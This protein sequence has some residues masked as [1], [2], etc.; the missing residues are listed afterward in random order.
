MEEKNWLSEDY[1][2][3][4]ASKELNK[5][6]R[7]LMSEEEFQEY[8]ENGNISYFN[9]VGKFKS[10]KRAMRR[11]HVLKNGMVAPN[12]PFNNRKNSS[13]RKGIHSR[14]TNETKKEIYG[15][16]RRIRDRFLENE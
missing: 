15:K 8:L 2:E 1:L 3:K 14:T 9:G 10:I 5:V 6:E 13:K 11:G 4:D 12:R 7:D 16:I